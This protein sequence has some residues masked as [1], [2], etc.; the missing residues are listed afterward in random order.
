VEWPAMQGWVEADLLGFLDGMQGVR[1]S[2]PLSST[3]TSQQVTASPLTYRRF[4]ALPGCPIRA[5]RVPL[6]AGG[7]L[8]ARADAAAISSSRAA[9]MAASRPA[10]TCW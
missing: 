9:A 3:T 6:G 2:N 5:T 4:L 8:S 1:G 10:I 7:G